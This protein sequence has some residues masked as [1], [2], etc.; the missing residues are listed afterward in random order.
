MK[1]F[2][3][4]ELKQLQERAEFFADVAPEPEWSVYYLAI[5]VSSQQL[6]TKIETEV[7]KVLVPET[8]Q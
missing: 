8:L 3:L 5:V 4:E 6:R 7:A 2:T 1:P